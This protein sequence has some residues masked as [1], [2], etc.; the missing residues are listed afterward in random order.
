MSSEARTPF[1]LRAEADR[2]RFQAE[3]KEH[4]MKRHQQQQQEHQQ[5]LLNTQKPSSGT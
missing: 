1:V 4:M 2:K 5:Q 3:M